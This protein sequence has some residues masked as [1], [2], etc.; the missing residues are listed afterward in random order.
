MGFLTPE[1]S[2]IQLFSIQVVLEISLNSQIFI[3][4][5]ELID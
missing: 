3:F 4:I 2:V 5:N 1:E